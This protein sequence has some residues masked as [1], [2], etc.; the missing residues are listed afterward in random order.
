MQ[1]KTKI[2]KKIDANTIDELTTKL[3]LLTIV[4]IKTQ[5]G[6]SFLH[7]KAAM[8]GLL[9]ILLFFFITF[10]TLSF[11]IKHKTPNT[12]LPPSPPALPIIGH[13]H[14]LSFLWHQ[15]FQKLA[16]Q[17]GPFIWL[18][19]GGSSSYIVSNGAIA[20]QVFKHHDISFAARPEFG[21]SEHQIYKDTLFSTL[22]YSKYWI[23]LKKICMVEI[24]SPQQINRFGDV[25]HEEMMKLLE[26]FLGCAEKGE[27]C[28]VGIRFMAMTN[29]L[30]C[31]LM[32]S[33]RCST[34]ENESS[35]IR[36]IAKGITL[37]SG[38]V[39]AGEIFGPLKKYDLFGAGKKIK[40][41]LLRFDKFM[42]GIIMQHENELQAGKKEKKD[43]MDILLGIADDPNAEMKLTRNGIKGL[44]LD[45]FLGGT[46]TTSVALQWALAELLNHPRTLKNLQEEIDRVVGI[47]RLVVKET[48]R[49][50]PSLPLVFR[51]C[52]EDC[53]INGY[54]IPK[55]SRL[56]VNL[57]AVNRNPEAWENAAEFVPERYLANTTEENLLI[58]PDELE[59]LQGQ[60]FDYVP[61]GGGRRGCPGAALAAAVLH[62][63][64][65]ATVQCFDWKIKG[66]ERV[67]MEEGVGFSA[68]MLHPLIC[69]PVTRA[70]PLKIA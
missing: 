20:K 14:L 10:I 15:S 23:F 62:S 40:A 66:A 21:S 32:M 31:R 64:L 56:V 50:H 69:Y 17:Y 8:D 68:A 28:D 54:K 57:Y 48:L 47:N 35:E 39:S 70:N 1:V 16:L 7:V 53:M 13:L 49:L 18:K 46:D 33:T 65:G 26:C 5:S 59:G 34:N 30:V 44:F 52:R 12:H 4:Y 25:R 19:T 38:Q 55:N 29:N 37:L 22:D 60:T 63:T 43:M 24:L 45:L 41:L 67:N 3:N 42:E 2:V 9:Y 27:S 51:K 58:Q 61:F 11:I 36:E 6:L